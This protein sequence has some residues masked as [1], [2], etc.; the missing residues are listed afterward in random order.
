MEVKGSRQEIRDLLDRE[1]IRELVIRYCDRVWQNDVEGYIDLF[2]PDC[3]VT[4]SDNKLTAGARGREQLRAMIVAGMAYEP[5]PFLHNHLIDL[6]GPD[7]A[8]GTCYKEI[9]VKIEGERYVLAA[10][11]HDVYVRAGDVWRFRSRNFI[12]RSKIKI[13]ELL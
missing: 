1:A 3:E 11:Y 4:S 10:E 2:T 13:T 8:K 5:R 9:R 6:T 7:T 12:T